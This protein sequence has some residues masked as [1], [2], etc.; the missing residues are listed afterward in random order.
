LPALAISWHLSPAL[1]CCC[2]LH[3]CVENIASSIIT[4]AVPSD[5]AV[6][7]ACTSSNHRRSNGG[8]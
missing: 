3:L 8:G 5:D 2:H 7:K 6:S 1:A 4:S